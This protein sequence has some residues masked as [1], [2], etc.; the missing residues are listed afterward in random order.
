VSWLIRRRKNAGPAGH[1][2]RQPGDHADP[3]ARLDRILETSAVPAEPAAPDRVRRLV[4]TS[5]AR[6]D[7]EEPPTERSP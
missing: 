7:A 2:A 3:I 1:S 5:P 6:I 4:S